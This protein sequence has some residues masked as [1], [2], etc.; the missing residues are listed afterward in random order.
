MQSGPPGWARSLLGLENTQ[1][2]EA[3]VRFEKILKKQSERPDS[4]TTLINNK[5][6]DS[7]NGFLYKVCATSDKPS[8]CT[9]CA[10]HWVIKVRKPNGKVDAIEAT[11]MQQVQA[12]MNQLAPKYSA[13]RS[14]VVQYIS[15]IQTRI[16]DASGP[17]DAVLVMGLVPFSPGEP[18]NMAELV[19]RFS[20]SPEDLDVLIIQMFLTLNVVTQVTPGF[21]HLDLLMNQVFLQRWPEDRAFE[22]LPTGTGYFLLPRRAFYGVLGDFGWST[23]DQEAYNENEFRKLRVSQ[24]CIRG[25]AQDIFR[26]FQGLYNAAKAKNSLKPA[27]RAHIGQLIKEIFKGHY[28]A[29]QL[30]KEPA[31]GKTLG[32]Y[33]Y[34][35]NASCEY[36]NSICPTYA[37][38][39]SNS[40]SLARYFVKAK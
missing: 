22:Q 40:K 5:P 28:G 9:T 39:V 21:R 34:L 6:S 32:F 35:D 15:H 2:E 7:S 25:P 12:G 19:T 3:L 13:Y 4:C 11:I 8:N 26:F 14:H 10:K 33:G 31:G 18:K 24:K 36:L 16:D 20:P 17:S 23:T 29:L 38:V 30:S 27:T 1:N 37:S